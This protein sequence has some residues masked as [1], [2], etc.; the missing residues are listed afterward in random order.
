MRISK[1]ELVFNYMIKHRSATTMELNAVD[2][3]GSEGTKRLRELRA[4]GRLNYTVD[5]IAGSAQFRYTL[6]DNELE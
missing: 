6:V 1:K 4:E 3:G 5:K 2:V